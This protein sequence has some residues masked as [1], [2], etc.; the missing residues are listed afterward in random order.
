MPLSKRI[1]LW[2][3]AL[4]LGIMAMIGYALLPYQTETARNV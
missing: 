3:L 2:H 4:V 1:R